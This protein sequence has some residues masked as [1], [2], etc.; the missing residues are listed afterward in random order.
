VLPACHTAPSAP[1]DLRGRRLLLAGGLSG[2]VL[3][4][5]GCFQQIGMVDIDAGKAGFLTA[6]YIVLVPVLGIVLRHKT[7]WNTWTSVLIAVV[8]L[9]CL[10]VKEGQ[11]IQFGDLVILIGAFGWACHILVIDHF[12]EGISHRA[13]LK[14]CVAQF[15]LAGALALVASLFLDRLFVPAPPTLA[16]LLDAAP[17]FLYVGILSTGIAFTFQAVGQQ[18]LSPAA[19]SLLMSLESVFAVIGG[20]LLLGESMDARE[21]IG[22]ALMFAA[23]ALSQLPVGRARAPVI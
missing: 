8:G 22:C 13:V 5:A 15:A 3:F 6:L 11:S 16:L 2:L 9:Y 12:V 17:A 19:A 1:G 23:V 7:H 4:F 14:L 10:C 20:T 21:Y 18:G